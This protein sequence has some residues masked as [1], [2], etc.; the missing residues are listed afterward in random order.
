MLEHLG[1]A[2]NSEVEE[3]WQGILFSF[4]L[5]SDLIPEAFPLVRGSSGNC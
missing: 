3:D 2:K 1:G 5:A 4:V